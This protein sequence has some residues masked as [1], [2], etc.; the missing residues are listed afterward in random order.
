MR[1]HGGGAGFPEGQA[2]DPEHERRAAEV[3]RGRAEGFEVG[4]GVSDGAAQG[5]GAP[6]QQPLAVLVV[7]V[8]R[9][10]ALLRP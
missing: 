8:D 9:E 5:V 10:G 2:L 7:R 6:L 3:V 4:L 1:A